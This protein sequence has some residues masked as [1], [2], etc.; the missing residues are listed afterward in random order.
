MQL[1]VLTYLY[2]YFLYKGIAK[3]FFS[4]CIFWKDTLNFEELAIFKSERSTDRSA[5]SEIPLFPHNYGICMTAGNIG[6][7]Y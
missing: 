5:E 2:I 7:N 4:H 6:T 3:S 1:E